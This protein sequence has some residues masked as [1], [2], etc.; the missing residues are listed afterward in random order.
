M[1]ID[2]EVHTARGVAY[3]DARLDANL[4]AGLLEAREIEGGIGRVEHRV[5]R[6]QRTD[7][8]AQGLAVYVNAQM[9]LMD[10]GLEKYRVDVDYFKVDVVDAA[11]AGPDLGEPLPYLPPI[12]APGTLRERVPVAQD[13]MIELRYPEVTSTSGT[14][15]TTGR[16]SRRS[17]SMARKL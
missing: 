10:W 6:T 15:W 1:R 13:S 16:R 17:R 9:A 11:T 3:T 14:S 2:V 7:R 8:Q 5:D 4:M 12:P